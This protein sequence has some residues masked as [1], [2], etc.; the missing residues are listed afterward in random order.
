MGWTPPTASAFK[1]FFNRDFN[2]A[3][4]DAPNDLEYICDNDINKAIAQ[5]QVN[6]SPGMFDVTSGQTTTVFMYKAAYSLVENIRN[7]ERGLAS[8][9]NFPISSDSVQGVS[10]TVEIP[11]RYKNSPDIVPYT[12]NGYGMQYL[13]FALPQCKGNVRPV[14]SGYG[15]NNAFFLR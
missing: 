14:G 1:S 11:E 7:S 12:S 2:Y 3:P 13:A 4:I 6:F 5:A 9:C 10:I 15:Y 8:Q